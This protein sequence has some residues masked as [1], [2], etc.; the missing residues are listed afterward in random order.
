MPKTEQEKTEGKKKQLSLTEAM[1]RAGEGLQAVVNLKL[2]GVVEVSRVE[3]GWRV[4]MEFVER[5]VIPDVRDLLGVYE[6]R[7]SEDGEMLG[8]RRIRVRRRS[9]VEET[10]E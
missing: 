5:A 4:T 7:L 8:Y 1:Q 9:D 3:E 2:S 6:V 10:V